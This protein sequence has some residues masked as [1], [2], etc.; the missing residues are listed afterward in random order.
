MGVAQLL[1]GFLGITG[2][3]TAAMGT[4][5]G[6]SQFLLAFLGAFGLVLNQD[7]ETLIKVRGERY[8]S[9]AEKFIPPAALASQFLGNLK[10]N[11][12]T[13]LRRDFHVNAGMKCLIESFYQSIAQ[14]QP[15]PIPYREILVTARIMDSIFEQVGSK[16]LAVSY[17]ARVPEE[18]MPVEMGS[19]RH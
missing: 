11:A 18:R 15:P 13:F 14:N 12:G 9:F 17:D 4:Q 3:R 19:R 6:I 7:Q 16:P 5:D 10:T 1:P 8:K 2:E